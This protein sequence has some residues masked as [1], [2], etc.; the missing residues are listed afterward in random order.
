MSSVELPT[1]GAQV[2]CRPSAARVPLHFSVA[3]Q[4]SWMP[5]HCFHLSCVCSLVKLY[6]DKYMK[7]QQMAKSEMFSPALCFN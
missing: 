7:S 6:L 3:A 4:N 2:G 5:W 1:A